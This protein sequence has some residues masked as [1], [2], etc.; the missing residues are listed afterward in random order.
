MKRNLVSLV[1]KTSEFFAYGKPEIDALSDRDPVLG[2]AIARIGHIFR[3]TTT[4]P[5]T[6]LIRSI[7]GQQISGK[8]H[9]AIWQ[10]FRQNYDR[11]APETIIAGGSEKLRLC[12]VSRTKATTILTVAKEFA[13]GCLCN[14]NWPELA[15]SEINEL[16]LKICGIGPWTVEMALIFTFHRPNVLSF[17][18]LAIRRGMS[19]LYQ[20]NDITK[21]FFATK[22]SLYA[23]YATIAGFY[24]WE[25]AAEKLTI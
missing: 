6:G 14:Q 5:F 24:L 4:D 3:K 25:L 15:D 16:L 19:R 8:A 7:S 10:R 11:I 17:G 20:I 22:K 23:P 18:D 12:G 21:E 9:A 13:G 2:K 1:A